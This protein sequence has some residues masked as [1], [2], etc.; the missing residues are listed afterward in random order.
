M[1]IL[2]EG[3]SR[4]PV[5]RA[6]MGTAHQLEA[7]A[8]LH[9][10]DRHYRIGAPPNQTASFREWGSLLIKGVTGPWPAQVARS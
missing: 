10:F 6:I 3:V 2:V 4:A 7:V 1:V 8:T 5:P 9:D